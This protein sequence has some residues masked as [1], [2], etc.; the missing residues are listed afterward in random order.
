MDIMAKRYVS[1]MSDL[2]TLQPLFYAS[3]KRNKGM[4]TPSEFH[5]MTRQLIYSPKG[6]SDP[7]ISSPSAW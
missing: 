7:T 3:G 5:S 2:L 6:F 1:E 4:N